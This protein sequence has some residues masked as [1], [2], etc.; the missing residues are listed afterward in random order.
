MRPALAEPR[1][2]PRARALFTRWLAWASGA[3]MP[4]GCLFVAASTELDDKPGPVRDRLAMWQH[5]WYAAI[6]RT[7]QLGVEAGAFRPEVDGEQFAQ[8]LQGILLAFHHRSRLMR[9]A[10]AGERARRAF[11]RL[12]ASVVTERKTV[13]P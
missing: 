8:D 5:D 6:A 7:Y 11:D 2:E 1:G 10:K 12:L 13:T 4:G 3:G 9:D